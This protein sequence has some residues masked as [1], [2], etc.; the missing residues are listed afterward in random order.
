MKCPCRL[1]AGDTAGWKTI[2]FGIKVASAKSHQTMNALHHYY[3]Q[4]S[5]Y[6]T[7]AL[8]LNGPVDSTGSPSVCEA[9]LSHW[10]LLARFRERLE[11]VFGTLTA[12][13][14]WN[15]SLR[16][17]QAADYLSLFLFGLLN[18][19]VRTMRGLCAAS[20][21]EKVQR[22]VCGR[23]VSLGSFSEAQ[24]LLDP[25]L[26][27]RVFEDVVKEL[28]PH[29]HPGQ[30]QRLPSHRPWLAR[31]GSLFR[32]LPRMSWALYGGGRGSTSRAVRLHLSFNV[33]EGQ[34]ARAQVTVG[35][36]CER[37]VWAEQLRDGEAYIGDRYFGESYKLLGQ[38]DKRGCSF[39]LRLREEAVIQVEEE[40]P[41][42]QAERGARVLRQAW[43]RLGSR[44]RTC[45]IRVRVLWIQ[46][47]HGEQMLLV[48]NLSPSQLSADLVALLYR[49]RWQVELF[50]RWL[51]Y[52]LDCRHWLAEG[53]KG[54]AIQLYLALIG[55]V[56]LQLYSGR[57]PSKRMLE[58]LQ[59]YMLGIASVEELTRGLERE[60]AR[61]SGRKT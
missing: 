40:L 47:R 30:D 18:P 57:R 52:L 4:I 50:F 59:F 23:S 51:K 55:A 14:S 31:D 15:D 16:R 38:L 60:R 54:P 44:Q 7:T 39:V 43:V 61:V 11:P 36:R 12:H 48:T 37:G 20:R 10:K 58:L 56:L 8:G 53:P 5:L 19:V 34:P 25:A 49:K 42:T 29:P 33:A 2:V 24:H 32:A 13:P 17:L 28:P 3:V 26:L 1:E 6:S 46:K 9:N 35:R 41:I 21:L 27:E 45:S 22:E